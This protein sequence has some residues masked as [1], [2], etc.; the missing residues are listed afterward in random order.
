MTHRHQLDSRRH[1]DRWH[2]GN[3]RRLAV[4]NRDG[5]VTNALSFA[6]GTLNAREGRAG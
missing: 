4:D 1:M 2:V 5:T 6:K 3:A